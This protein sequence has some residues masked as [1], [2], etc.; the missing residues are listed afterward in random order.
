MKIK[1]VF[2]DNTRILKKYTCD[3]DNV[4][5][6]IEISDVPTGAKSLILIVDDPDAP[7]GTFVHWLVWNISPNTKKI[8]EDSVP[9]N[10]V[11]GITDF[12]RNEYGG[13]CPPSGTHRYKF[14]LYALDTILNIPTN[15]KSSY[16][17]K[18]M[19]GH[20]LAQTVLTGLYSRS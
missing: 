5:P 8:D 20:I 6:A 3:G 13:P 7:G 15:S 1:S 16:V 19:Q 9:S 14:K 4:N 2:T 18:A 17:Q 11:Q 10:A 12:R